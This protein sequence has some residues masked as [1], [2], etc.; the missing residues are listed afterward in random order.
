MQATWPQRWAIGVLRLFAPVLAK[1]EYLGFS[2]LVFVLAG[3]C[4][5]S[6]IACR[7]FAGGKN[8]SAVKLLE[9]QFD[10]VGGQRWNRTTDTGIFNLIG[11][12]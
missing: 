6:G 5:E 4:A 7:Y 9:A 2:A 11:L 10:V 12:P 3:E 1:V 8:L